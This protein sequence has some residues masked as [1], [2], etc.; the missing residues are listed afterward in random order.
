VG[1]EHYISGLPPI[2]LYFSSVDRLTHLRWVAV[3]GRPSISGLGSGGG[4][5]FRRCMVWKRWTCWGLRQCERG[6]EAGTSGG[7]NDGWAAAREQ[8]GGGRRVRGEGRS[9]RAQG[10]AEA[11]PWSAGGHRPSG[12]RSWSVPRKKTICYK[13][14]SYYLITKRTGYWHK[15]LLGELAR[16]VA[17]VSWDTGSTPIRR[18]I[19]FP[20]LHNIHTWQ[21]GS[22]HQPQ[23]SQRRMLQLSQRRVRGWTHV[24]AGVA[25]LTKC[26]KS[27]RLN[28]VSIFN[29][30]NTLKLE[31]IITFNR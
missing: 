17:L 6:V 10:W 23:R 4:R 3:G 16:C 18:G 1:Q 13:L 31:K 24:S 2:F 26:N 9:S 5:R 22:A 7:E 14:P 25:G 30:K 21:A 19:A 11:W 8:G 27:F 29:S 15:Q 28:N 20:F 12:C